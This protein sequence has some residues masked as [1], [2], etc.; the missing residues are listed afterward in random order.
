MSTS[1]PERI[2]GHPSRCGSVTLSKRCVNQLWISGSNMTLSHRSNRS[3]RLR[4]SSL[5]QSVY[6]LIER[7]AELR[8]NFLSKLLGVV[9]G[10]VRIERLLRLPHLD[11]GEVILAI[12][13]Q[14]LEAHDPRVLPAVGSEFLQRLDRLRQA[15]WA[16]GDIHVDH[17]VKVLAA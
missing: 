6:P 11:D 15:A 10:G 17:H 1:L 16:W 9:G 5:Q 13:L 7:A 2:S 14:N 3:G 8:A 4:Y 12:L